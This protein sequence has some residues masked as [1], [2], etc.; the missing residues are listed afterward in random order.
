MKEHVIRFPRQLETEF[1]PDAIRSA[2]AE[3]TAKLWPGGELYVP[4]INI[5][6]PLKKALQTANLKGALRCGLE[7]ASARLKSEK[8]GIE[9]V[10]EQSEAAYGERVSRLMLFSNDGAE[11]FYRHAEQLVL[12]HAP[13]LLA[14]ILDIDSTALGKLITGKDKQIKLVM[15]EHKDG[16]SE[17]LRAILTSRDRP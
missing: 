5:N 13:R 6:V 12:L 15:A 7:G 4:L 2:L 16:V 1:D 10:R 11:R 14:C 17:I 8:A 9:N 3:R